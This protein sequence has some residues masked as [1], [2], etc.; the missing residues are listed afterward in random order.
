MLS[1]A[2][3]KLMIKD[4]LK[5]HLLELLQSKPTGLGFTD[6]DRM[7]I[8]EFTPSEVS[9]NLG[10]CFTELTEMGLIERMDRRY[11]ITQNG[12]QHLKERI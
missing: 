9:S 12:M 7:L 1:R 4:V 10:A 11:C 6:I 5:L 8:S 2:Y 3:L